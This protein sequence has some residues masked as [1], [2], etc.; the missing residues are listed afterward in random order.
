MPT[1]IIGMFADIA[2]GTQDAVAS[3]DIPQDGALTGIDWDVRGDLDADAEEMDVELSF[4]ATNQLE[5]NDVRGRIS[6]VGAEISLTT[7]GVAVCFLQKFVGPIEIPVSGGERLYLHAKCTTG[8]TGRIRCNIHFDT[9]S[10]AQ[11]RSARRR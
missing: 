11:R 6:S 7:S 3:I 8:L 10:P 5:T 4:I 1:E 2:G 9:A